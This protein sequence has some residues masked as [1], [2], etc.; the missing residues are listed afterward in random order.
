MAGIVAAL[1]P[2]NKK[3]KDNKRMTSQIDAWKFP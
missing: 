1:K 3:S 2:D